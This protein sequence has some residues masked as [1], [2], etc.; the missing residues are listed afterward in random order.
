[1]KCAYDFHIHTALSPCASNEMLPNDIVNMSLLNGLNAIAITDHNTCSNAEA[2]MNVGKKLGLVVIPG[3]EVQTAE[4]VHVVC[5]FKNIDDAKFV[6][7]AVL[8]NMMTV[9]NKAELFGNQYYADEND[10]ITGEEENLLIL[11]TELTVYDLKELVD[12]NNGI[13]IPA[14]IDKDSNSIISNL[15]VIPGDLGVDLVEFSAK[16]GMKNFDYEKY[17]KEYFVLSSSD[18]HNLASI[19][20]GNQFLDVD[21]I[22]LDCIFETLKSKTHKRK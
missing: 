13:F 1:M 8:N 5:L 7:R 19:S 4:E 11:S 22:S 20:L 9:K 2:V 16:R 15:G 10:I 3:L 17:E 14:H 21:E 12:N 18:A 6:E